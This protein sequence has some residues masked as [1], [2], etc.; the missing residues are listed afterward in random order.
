MKHAG[1]WWGAILF[2]LSVALVVGG[3][4]WLATW[5]VCHGDWDCIIEAF[6][7]VQA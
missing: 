7:S 5:Q 3:L 2:G 4:L 6:G 1:P